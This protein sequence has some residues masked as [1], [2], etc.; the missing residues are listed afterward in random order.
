MNWLIFS[1][2]FISGACGLIYEVVWSRMMLPI[3]GRSALAVGT[4]L[5]AFML[6]LAIGSY[7]LGKL[8]DRSRNP[9]RLY[10]FYELGIGGAA[11]LA[12]VLLTRSTPVYLWAHMTFGDSSLEF[13][14]CRFLIAFVP[15]LAPTILMGATLPILSR[16]VVTQLARV[17]RD[18]GRLYAINTVGAVAGSLASGFFL[19]GHIG[20]HDTVYCAVAGNLTVGVLA[21]LASSRFRVPNAGPLTSSPESPALAPSSDNRGG[22]TAYRIILWSFALSGFASFAYEVFW[23]RSLVFLVGNTTYAF[24]LMLVAFLSGIALG[25]YGIRFAA[26][27]FKNHLRLFAALEILIGVFSASSLPILF[28][29][30]TSES[31]R[32]LISRM[33]GQLGFLVLSNF[34]VALILM[35]IPATLIG[36]TFPLIGRIFLDDL[37]NTGTTVGK[38]YAVNTLGNVLGALLPG[39]VILPFLGIQKGIL[40]M[41]ALNVCIGIVAAFSRRKRALAVAMATAAAFAVCAVLLTH[42]SLGFQFPSEFQTAKDET[43][44][45]R[46]GGL[47]TTKVWASADTGYKI[48][49]VDGI[50]IGGT[51]DSDYKQQILAHLPKLLLKSYRSELTVGFGS[52]ILA[53]ESGRH[54][55][56]QRIVCVELARGVVEGARYF[57]H[58]N[59]DILND[60][61]TALVV[62]DI[63]DFLQT[64]RERFDII[65]ADEKTTGKYA[66]NSMSY[67]KDYYALLR[68]HLA[69]GGLVIQWMPADLPPS[70]YRLAMRTFLDSFPHVCLWYFPPVGRFAMSNTFLVG[71]NDPIDI[72]AAWMRQAMEKN[73]EAFEGIRKYGLTTAESIL[74]HFVATDETLRTAFPPGPVNSFERPYYEFYSPRDYAVPSSER[75]RANH[76]MLMS[77]RGVDTPATLTKRVSPPDKARLDD[78]FRAEGIFFAGYALQLQGEMNPSVMQYYDRAIGTAPGNMSLRNEVVAYLNNE[79]QAYFSR[80][81]TVSALACRRRAAELYPENAEV[82]YDYALMLLYVNETETGIAELR[83]ALTLN[84]ISVPALRNLG[85]AYAGR[86]QMDTAVELW[87]QALAIDPDDVET[88]VFFGSYLAEQKGSREGVEYL[89][90]AYRLAPH[91]PQVVDR[92]TLDAKPGR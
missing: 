21:L 79:V 51:S 84:P 88:L 41:A 3:F 40:L 56:L 55:A 16:I 72:N 83:R 78:A 48:I 5:A 68:E 15:L 74:A 64:S 9:L 45:Y 59:Y 58:E 30:V 1:L 28:S 50:G 38:V 49:S 70:Q 73:P 32:S 8:S 37:K 60:P 26:A 47:V 17:E 71:S 43:L 91:N 62:D 61:R 81:D 89:K 22:G 90:R 7:F 92:H 85:V 18:L 82:H 46:E 12:S 77:F 36:A 87:R 13:A 39:L 31:V 6:G 66:S 76:E 57:T 23:T 63:A 54:T 2:F 86:G 44:F 4:V 25:G 11:F 29:I 35:L 65:S 42:T 10:A 14:I 27:R 52:G 20:L 19:I 67:S 33:S 53:G 80:G 34:G 69:P 75:S 24:S